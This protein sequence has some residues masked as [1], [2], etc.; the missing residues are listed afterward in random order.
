MIKHFLVW[1]VLVSGVVSAQN[2]RLD[3]ADKK[4]NDYSYFDAIELYEKVAAKG[5]KSPELFEKLADSYYFNADFTKAAQWY[6]QLFV[7]GVAPD[8]KYY[9]RYAQS[10]KSIGRYASSDSIM[11][12]FSQKVNGDRRAELF[13]TQKDYLKRIARNSGRFNIVN[14]GIN[15]PYS[16][17]GTA[18][19]GEEL[20]F[21]TA[22]DT[23]GPAS[24][25]MKWTGEA[26]SQLYSAK[27]KVDGGFSKPE[28]FSKDVN[29]KFNES[30]A[31]FAKDKKTMYFTRNNFA[32]GEKGTSKEKTT[33]LKIYKAT[34]DGVG[35]TD[36]EE[37]PFNSDDF[38][39]AHPALSPDDRTLYF[40]SDRPGT[41]GDSDIFKVAINRDG[42]FGEPINLGEDINTEARETFPFVSDDGELYF[43]SEGH[44]GLGGL[45][46][47]VA[48]PD[49][50][51]HFT[52]ENI[53][54]PAN[55]P[56]DDFAFMIDS[57]SRNGFLSS[58]R[59]KGMGSDDIY[60]FTETRK[61]VCE[62][63][64]AGHVVDAET[65]DFLVD[66]QVTL[67]DENFTM[68]TQ[69]YA[70][71][72]GAFSFQVKCGKKYYLRATKLHFETK[73]IEISIPEEVG[74]TDANLEL[75]KRK[76]RFKEGDDVAKVLNIPEIKF[77]TDKSDIRPDAAL[78]LE[79]VYNLMQQ[80]PLMRIEIR[81]HTDSRAPKTYNQQLSDRRAKSTMAWLQKRGIA[82]FRLAAKGFGESRLV[83]RCA[84][85]VDC[86][87]AEHQ[88]NR[89]SEFIVT[90]M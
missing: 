23:G 27:A 81:S 8:A 83:N 76:R 41:R 60:R 87:E 45:D 35:W 77:D 74:K 5:Y 90:K 46:I 22:R 54:E 56:F 39:C 52:V 73:E 25:K 57:K 15:S 72:F 9:F 48:T 63:A 2:A 42:T 40:A 50:K 19:F 32:D 37:L 71:E 7:L 28:P 26:F 85:G 29:T 10:L 11:T 43:A 17:Y 67:F 4:Y 61:I 44:P 65:G 33:L 16:D 69:Q 12:L 49:E 55:T 18:F 78:E 21:A 51:G 31:A 80:Y 14:A 6:R 13:A 30:T 75:E 53:G 64:L 86:T 20:V 62:Q 84:D 59:P 3:A 68:I 88:Q 66:A 38:S 70:A 47:F 36:I 34:F 1:I 89:R 24:R 58:N 82:S 79:K